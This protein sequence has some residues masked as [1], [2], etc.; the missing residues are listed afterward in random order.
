[1]RPGVRGAEKVQGPVPVGG[2]A[3]STEVTEAQWRCPQSLRVKD[4]DFQT[5][6]SGDLLEAT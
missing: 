4:L 3:S 2:Q 6:V 1:M 5:V